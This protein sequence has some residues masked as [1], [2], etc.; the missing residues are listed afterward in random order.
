MDGFLP[1]HFAAQAGHV[2]VLKLLVRHIGSKGEYGAMK[3]HV[4]CVVT[5]GKKTALH[6]ALS[7]G[8]AEC[9]RFLVLKGASCE[10]KTAQNQTALDLCSEELKEELMGKAKVAAKE[11]EEAERAKKD[12]PEAKKTE[13][14]EPPTKKQKTGVQVVPTEAIE[15]LPPTPMPLTSLKDPPTGLLVAGPWPL[16]N[17]DLV[18]DGEKS[19]PAGIPGMADVEWDLKIKEEPEEDGI[20]W[21]FQAL[22]TDG[23]KLHLKMKKSS[24]KLLYYTHLSDE[25]MMLDKD[26][27]C[28]ACGLVI[29]LETSDRLLV[30]QEGKSSPL[31][32]L[33]FVQVISE[34]LQS[35]CSPEILGT[36]IGST[37]IL[38]LLEAPEAQDGFRHHL[39]AACR[40]ALTSEEVAKL[41]K[42]TLLSFREGTKTSG[43]TT[44]LEE[45]L[46]TL[47]DELTH[48]S[49]AL[50]RALLG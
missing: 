21:C 43:T 32:S 23:N 9:G 35:L 10:M 2:E 11:A 34:A 47:T 45:Y 17:I 29:L 27:K 13:V 22:E 14:A 26:S 39:V 19:Y 15:G 6:L 42:V 28:N 31:T 18:D 4:N 46:K 49:V 25:A 30:C 3:K 5:K 40:I 7:K 20:V 38:G 12:T 41:H 44:A 36:A 16:E 50:L 1:L 33:D 8:H 48:R 24:K 37:R